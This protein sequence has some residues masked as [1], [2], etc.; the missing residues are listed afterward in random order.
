[1]RYCLPTLFYLTFGCRFAHSVDGWRS[2]G[3]RSGDVGRRTGSDVGATG[4]DTVDF[5]TDNIE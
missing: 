1:M 4:T 3:D 5:T 2:S